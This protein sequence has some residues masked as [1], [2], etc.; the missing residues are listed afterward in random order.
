MTPRK[1]YLDNNSTTKVAPEVVEAMRPYFDE[2]YGNPS[3][4]H[5]TGQEAGRAVTGSRRTIAEL[6]GAGEKE[7]IFTSGATESNNLAL[8]GAAR[9]RK[10]IGKHII[11]TLVE[12]D[13]VLE[14]CQKL[15]REGFFVTYLEPDR[16]GRVSV[17]Q[18]I[19]ALRKDTVLVAVMHVQN[20]LG[21]IYPI[22]E[23]A[24]ELKKR[25]PDVIFFSDGAQAFGKLPVT[26]DKIDL[27]SISAHK[28]HGPKGIGALYVR[29]GVE[30]EPIMF[31]GGQEQSRRP[32][33]ENVPGIVGFAKAA[34][35]A[36]ANL[37]KYRK[38][39]RGLRNKLMSTLANFDGAVVNSPEDGLE[40]T[41][42][43]AFSNIPAETVLRALEEKGILASAG[44]ACSIKK[45]GTSHV[46]E[47]LPIDKKIARASLRFGL[48]RYNAEEEIDYL[49]KALEK[50]F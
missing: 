28:I 6:L 10:N 36:Y 32:G 27:Y 21:T 5:R 30:L 12:H 43:V 45:G 35:I 38:H 46:L 17:E 16:H 49:I 4:V 15:E 11:A 19:A 39:I 24:R 7:V 23:M 48:S 26:L 14:P 44:S 47:A 42:N 13:S 2:R 31:G 1:I 40:T 22:N 34:E 29:S 41:V 8:L 3:S 37:E 33:T 50:M 25:K 20:E 9:A 18:A